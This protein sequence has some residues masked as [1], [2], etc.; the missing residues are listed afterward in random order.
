MKLI[1]KSTHNLKKRSQI[2]NLTFHLQ[3]LE[4]DE[5]TKVKASRRTGLTR[6]EWKLIKT[7]TEKQ[8]RKSVKPNIG[9]SKR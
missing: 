9:S 7:R 3:T 4:I 6:V 2:N 5:Q 8:L 1:A